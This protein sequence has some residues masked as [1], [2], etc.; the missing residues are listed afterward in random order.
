[1]WKSKVVEMSG[2]GVRD[3]NTEGVLTIDLDADS[4]EEGVLGKRSPA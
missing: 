4:P 2:S 3:T 1:M